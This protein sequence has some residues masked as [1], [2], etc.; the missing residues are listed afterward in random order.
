L[1]SFAVG[2]KFA[3]SSSQWEA[4]VDTWINVPNPADQKE[5]KKTWTKYTPT[6][7]L[8]QRKLALTARNTLFDL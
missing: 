5:A 2:V 1:F 3:Q 4:S 6:T 8:S 7:V